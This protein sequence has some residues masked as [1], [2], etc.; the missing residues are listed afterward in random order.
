MA[1]F[2]CTYSGCKK[3]AKGGFCLAEY[4]TLREFIVL[5]IQTAVVLPPPTIY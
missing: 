3:A 4:G 1:S 2:H 5:N